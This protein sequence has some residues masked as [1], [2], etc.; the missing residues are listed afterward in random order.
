MERGVHVSAGIHYT[1]VA[2][3]VSR[4]KMVHNIQSSVIKQ[5]QT[6]K[7]PRNLSNNIVCLYPLHT[8][9]TVTKGHPAPAIAFLWGQLLAARHFRN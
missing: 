1:T 7:Q 6:V 5:V 9:P 3:K 8:L 4:T 2:S